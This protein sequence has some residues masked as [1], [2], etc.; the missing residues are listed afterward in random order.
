MSES[1][2]WKQ[3]T[4]RINLAKELENVNVDT[5]ANQQS[6]MANPN[7]GFRSVGAGS[8]DPNTYAKGVELFGKNPREITFANQG[9][10]MST[11]KAFQRVA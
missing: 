6:S 4:D 2:P 8:A 10:I 1:S 3:A 9:G 11:N 5:R 7:L